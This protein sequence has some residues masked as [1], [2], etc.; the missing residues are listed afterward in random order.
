VKLGRLKEFFLGPDNTFSMGRLVILI[1]AVCGAI[2]TLE[3]AVVAAYEVF[4]QPVPRSNVGLGLATLGLT[5][6]TGSIL[7]KLGAGFIEGKF[8]QPPQGGQGGGP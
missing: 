8:G 3:G 7:T 2:I 4:W 5:T 6:L 1:A